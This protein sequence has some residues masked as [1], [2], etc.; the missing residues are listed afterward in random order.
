MNLLTKEINPSS[1]TLDFAIES[2][3]VNNSSNYF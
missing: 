1:A 3:K 2:A